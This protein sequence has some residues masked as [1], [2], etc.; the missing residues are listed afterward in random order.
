MNII[1]IIMILLTSV[2]NACAEEIEL[3]PYKAY[4][5]W[6]NQQEESL[7]EISNYLYGQNEFLNL[8]KVG[9]KMTYRPNSKSY[10]KRY[11]LKH[12][13]KII[14]VMGNAVNIINKNENGIEF[15]NGYALSC[16]VYKCTVSVMNY[17]PKGVESCTNNKL[18]TIPGECVKIIN[19]TWSIRYHY[20]YG[21]NAPDNPLR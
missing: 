10:P 2:V 11:D 21:P 4:E 18:L 8:M 13:E 20:F 9:S 17:L 14:N 3:F 7:N 19:D 15:V 12:A 5:K 6:V 16:G 1:F